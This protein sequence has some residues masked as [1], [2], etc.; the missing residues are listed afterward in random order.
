MGC[1]E[2]GAEGFVPD[3]MAPRVA[4][5]EKYWGRLVEEGWEALELVVEVEIEGVAP[6]SRFWVEAL[7]MDGGRREK[8]VS[9]CSSHLF[10]VCGMWSLSQG[11]AL[12]DCGTNGEL[13]LVE[14]L[15][16]KEM[17]I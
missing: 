14:D 5:A 11:E 2:G 1:A 16:S 15:T 4:L 10:D 13:K 12:A 17:M 3:G 8:A 9:T 6:V 7:V